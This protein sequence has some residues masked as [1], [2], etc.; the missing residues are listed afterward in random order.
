MNIAR[1]LRA[2]REQVGL[3]QEDLAAVAGVSRQ[4]IGAMEADTNLPRVD[5]AIAIA[6][7]LGVNV[8][9][10][11]GGFDQ[12]VDALTGMPPID[13]NVLMGRVGGQLVTT[14]VR[15][16]ASGFE[17]IDAV[18]AGGHLESVSN[19]VP[20]LVVAG[21]EPGLAIVEQTLKESGIGAM[22]VATSSTS[23]LTA[24]DSGRA[25]LAAVHGSKRELDGLARPRSFNR[26]HLA[27]WRV[28]MSRRTSS[29]V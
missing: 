18:V 3:S 26:L 29:S 14:P 17:S 11:F 27:G 5:V 7:A 28:P 4:T 8:S 23:A 9:E 16:G 21:C 6:G 12:A 20:G 10:L 1:R 2:R 15:R 19:V 22:W 24:L 13:G 25:H